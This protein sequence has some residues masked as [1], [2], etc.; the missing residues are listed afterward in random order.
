MKISVSKIVLLGAVFATG[1]LAITSAAVADYGLDARMYR[2][3]VTNATRGQ[4]VAP[5]VIATHTDAFRLFELGPTP[6]AGD[7]GYDYYFALATNGR[8]RLSVPPA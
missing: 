6:A 1:S 4:P 8:D 7:V 2:V 3:T 5:S